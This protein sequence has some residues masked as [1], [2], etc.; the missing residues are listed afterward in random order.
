MSTSHL[1]WHRLPAQQQGLRRRVS[2]CLILYQ[3]AIAYS[4]EAILG[5]NWL[6]PPS[7]E[8]CSPAALTWLLGGVRRLLAYMH[9]HSIP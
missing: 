4:E 7:W 6:L 1:F 9:I 8:I 5:L 3:S 2:A